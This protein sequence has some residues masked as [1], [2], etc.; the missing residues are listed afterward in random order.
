MWGGRQLAV[1]TPGSTH[2]WGYPVL[3]PPR[4]MI[5]IYRVHSRPRGALS[6]GGARRNVLKDQARPVSQLQIRLCRQHLFLLQSNGKQTEV[7][8]YI[9][10][11]TERERERGRREMEKRERER[12]RDM[13]IY[14]YIIL[15]CMCPHTSIYKILLCPTHRHRASMTE[16]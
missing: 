5:R 1:Y 3:R 9:F 14:I 13:Y 16:K 8:P 2:V 10:M 15:L 4:H 6:G 11:A 7:Y 12:E